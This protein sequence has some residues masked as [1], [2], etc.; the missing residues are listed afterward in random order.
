ME[1][2]FFSKFSIVITRFIQIPAI[3]NV[4]KL[5]SIYDKK[6]LKLSFVFFLNGVSHTSK[7]RN[8]IIEPLQYRESFNLF[9]FFERMRLCY[10]HLELV[11]T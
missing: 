5:N 10:Y 8:K 7:N 2:T 6:T 4:A 9:R 11:I 3:H 1:M